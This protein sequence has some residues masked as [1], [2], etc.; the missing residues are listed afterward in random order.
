MRNL[1]QIF[2]EGEETGRVHEQK[3]FGRSELERKKAAKLGKAGKIEERER[4][5]TSS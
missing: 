2:F 4:E 5:K 1:Q 3:E